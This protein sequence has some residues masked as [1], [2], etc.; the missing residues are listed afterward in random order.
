MT[1]QENSA[2]RQQFDSVQGYLAT[3]KPPAAR[4]TAARIPPLEIN[5][6][7]R[8]GALS[9][10][11][12]AANDTQSGPAMGADQIAP[13]ASPLTNCRIFN[14]LVAAKFVPAPPVPD[15]ELPPPVPGYY[16]VAMFL[17][18]LDSHQCHFY[19][20]VRPPRRNGRTLWAEITPL[21]AQASCRDNFGRDIT[22]PRKAKYHARSVGPG[23]IERGNTPYS[24][25]CFFYV[26]NEGVILE[27][28][29]RNRAVAGGR[30]RMLI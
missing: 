9:C 29:L 27:A 16:R 15:T 12:Y 3:C 28:A 14:A 20:E 26:P 21:D 17:N 13:D 1:G 18:P 22:D 19:R 2:F 24:F 8:A 30:K 25:V 4:T 10:L 6:N 5:G 11:H 23:G 7:A